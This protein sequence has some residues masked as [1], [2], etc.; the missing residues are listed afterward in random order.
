MEIFKKLDRNGDGRVSFKELKQRLK[1]YDV[2]IPSSTVRA[3]LKKADKNEDGYLD[4]SEFLAIVK[5]NHEIRGLLSESV[6]R[7]IH[8]VC[9]VP[10]KRIEHFGLDVTDSDIQYEE[11]YSC[12]PPPLF[13]ITITILE[14]QRKLIL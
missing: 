7:W 4:Y 10:K 1:E 11:H 5:N 13:M 2:D 3:I 6:D 8:T 12:F 14:V 9:V